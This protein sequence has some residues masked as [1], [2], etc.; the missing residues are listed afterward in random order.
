M[1]ESDVNPEFIE[2][3]DEAKRSLISRMLT[4]AT[5]VAPTVAS[6]TM[7]DLSLD[8]TQTRTYSANT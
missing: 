1:L 5:Y 7:G 6:F 8:E 4:E 3:I 2:R